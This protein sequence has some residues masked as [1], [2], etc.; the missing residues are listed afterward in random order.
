MVG[1]RVGF[2]GVGQMGRPMVERLLSAGYPVTV[3]VRRPEVAAEL[4]NAGAQVLP[5]PAEVAAAA[6]V[7][8]VCLFSD[9]QLT[10]LLLGA[11]S[12]GDER[13]PLVIDALR[14]GSYLVNHVTG[15]PMLAQELARRAPP[16]VR[17]VDAPMSGTGRDIRAGRLTLLVGAAAEDVES[18]RPVLAA[19]AEPVIHV[20]AVGD[21]QRI[22]LVNNL[23]FTVHLRIA[24][25]AARLGQSVGIEPAD[26]ARVLA[27]CSGNSYAVALLQQAPPAAITE[28]ARPYLTKDVAVVRQVA[29]GLGID[30]GLLGALSTWVDASDEPR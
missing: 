3:Y 29:E 26:L 2:I 14:P 6:D 1:F 12:G 15:S 10:E 8:C 18:V 25:E 20:G 16:G 5:T 11:N 9:T 7:L 28:S 13:H 27:T 23:L 17:Y 24:L 19:Y 4:A 21:G 30:L 22:K